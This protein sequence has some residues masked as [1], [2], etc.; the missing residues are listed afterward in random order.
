[1][2]IFEKVDESNFN[3]KNEICLKNFGIK[4]VFNKCDVSENPHKP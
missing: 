1:M 4:N 3:R 2:E